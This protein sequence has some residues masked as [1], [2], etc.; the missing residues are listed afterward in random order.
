MS[1]DVDQSSVPEPQGHEGRSKSKTL[2]V[3]G[4][5]IIYAAVYSQYLGFR[6]GPILGPLIVYGVPI[7]AVT[8]LWG[9]GILKRFFNSTYS[10]LKLGLGFFGA[11]TVLGILVAAAILYFLTVFSPATVD[12][13][14]KPNPVLEV[15]R[16]FAWVM[17]VLSL[18]VVGPAEEY[19]FRGFMF[20]AL[21]EIFRD[22]HWLIIALISSTL[23]SLVHL[24][25]AIV[26]G[27]ASLIQFT[28]LI[29]FGMGMAATYHLS[30]GNLL[31]PSLIHGVYDATAFVGVAT[32]VDVGARLREYMILMGIIVG[33]A[34]LI[35]KRYAKDHNSHSAPENRRIQ[36][37]LKGL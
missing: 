8:L 26:Y 7:L 9:T 5:A 34:L 3:A 27:L 6:F 31:V 18:V 14:N 35:Q 25:Y 16:G 10:A 30:G 19:V 21:L 13:L 24:Y 29:T 15:P 37:T 22:R 11:F 23:F 28:D 36:D 17:V 20:G 4:V 12:L 1:S 2:Y 33:L 32:S